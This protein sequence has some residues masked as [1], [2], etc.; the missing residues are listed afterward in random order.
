MA[1]K[2]YIT[3]SLRIPKPKYT[4]VAKLAK[5]MGLSP[6]V[7]ARTVLYEKC[8]NEKTAEGGK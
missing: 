3:V 7:F 2:E 1:K 5:K 4:E 6:G 8:E